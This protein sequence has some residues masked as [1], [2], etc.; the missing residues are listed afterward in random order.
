AR[1]NLGLGTA[2]TLN[3]GTS[4]GNIPVL[5]SGGVLPTSV[6]PA[7]AIVEVFVVASQSAQLALIAEEGDVAVRTDLNKS[8]IHNGGSAGTMADWQELLTPTDAVT[9]VNGQ[10]GVVVLTKSDIGL[11]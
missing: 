7:V 3:I 6:I 5:G 8:Y 10:T 1:N 9:S 2:A 11:G 4:S